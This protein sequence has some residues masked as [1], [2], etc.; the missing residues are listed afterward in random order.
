MAH[1][2]G[3][4]GIVYIASQLLEDC[5]DDWVDGTNG[6]SDLEQTAGLFKV[7]SG[8]VKITGSTVS[9]GNILA[10]EQ[11]AS[12][13]N[14]STYTHGICWARCNATLAAADLRLALDNTS[15]CV[16]PESLLDFPALT[17]DTW[18]LCHLT[19]VGTDPLDDST[20]ADFVGLE[21]NANAQDKIV[22]LDDI[23][24]AKT[25]AGIKA[26]TLDYTVDMLDTTDFTDGAATNNARTFL[27]GLSQW[28]GTFEGVKDGAPLTIFSQVSIEL[29]ESAT[30]TQMWLGNVV[31]TGIHP[32]VATDGLVTYTYDYQGVGEL[33]E[34]ST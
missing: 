26:W 20:I 23:R 16:S 27:P 1:L 5:E 25:I 19:E 2:S 24:A 13:L 11:M 7:G 32:N 31:I 9:N 34:S 4:T 6:T 3:R 14:L 21:W 15:A 18:K 28:S 17:A 8:S 29:A 33:M 10:Y 30:V 22:Y 12:T